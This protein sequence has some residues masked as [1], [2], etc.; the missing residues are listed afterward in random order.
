[1]RGGASRGNV[2][3][4]VKGEGA[5]AR[6][7]RGEKRVPLWVRCG[8]VLASSEKSRFRIWKPRCRAL[9]RETTRS[10]GF[11]AIYAGE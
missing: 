2:S 3:R 6:I 10:S 7:A 5:G 1:M 8:I 11:D 4:R 9:D